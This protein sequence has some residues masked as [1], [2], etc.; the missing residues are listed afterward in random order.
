MN[1]LKY[2]LLGAGFGCLIGG[3]NLLWLE[4]NTRLGSKKD[5]NKIQISIQQ[6]PWTLTPELCL[7]IGYVESRN[8]PSVINKA[9]CAYGIY[10]IRQPM[11]DTINQI[12]KTHLKIRDALDPETASEIMRLYFEFVHPS[13]DEEAARLW[14]GGVEGCSKNTTRS[15]WY[16]VQ[17]ARIKY[18]F[19]K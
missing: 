14:N 17:K 18:D 16:K 4:Q 19:A 2:I 10:Q 12:Y 3:I 13:S 9:E 7:A 15:Y 11:I 1:D 6:A 8:N 5:Q